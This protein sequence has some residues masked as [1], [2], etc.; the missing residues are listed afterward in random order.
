MA[1]LPGGNDTDQGIIVLTHLQ[2]APDR[3]G[4]HSVR[5]SVQLLLAEN[6]YWFV[7]R[8]RPVQSQHETANIGYAAALHGACAAS[9]TQLMALHE[10]IV[11]SAKV[12]CT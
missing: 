11:G 5:T 7:L 9:A 8:F 6:N 12:C 10:I 2:P 3:S 1:S 4:A